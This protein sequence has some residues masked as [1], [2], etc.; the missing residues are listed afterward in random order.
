MS[1]IRELDLRD[2]LLPES[3]ATAWF[4]EYINIVR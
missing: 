1:N 2:W 4:F 3:I